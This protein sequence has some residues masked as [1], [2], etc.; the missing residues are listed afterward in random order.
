MIPTLIPHKILFIAMAAV[1]AM[2][3]LLGIL[4]LAMRGGTAK[5][6]E[7]ITLTVWGFEDEGVYKRTFDTFKQAHPKTEV[8]YRKQNPKQYLDR[9]KTRRNNTRPGERPDIFLMHN[10]WSLQVRDLVNPAPA[11]VITEKTFQQLFYPVA[12][13]DFVIDGQI[14]GLPTSSDNLALFYNPSLLAE[15][16]LSA[17]QD[18]EAFSQAAVRLTTR[19]DTGT[20]QT[21]GAAIGAAKN[22]TYF[23]D[24]LGAMFLQQGVNPTLLG[25]EETDSIIEYYAGDITK[26]AKGVGRVWDPNAERDIDAFAKGKVAMIF[27]PGI[28]AREIMSKNPTLIFTTAPVPQLRPEEPRTFATYWAWGVSRYAPNSHLAWQL[29]WKLTERAALI[30]VNNALVAQ[31]R[32][33]VPYPRRDMATRQ[34]N[35]PVLGAFIRQAGDAESLVMASQTQDGGMNDKINQLLADAITKKVSGQ[36]VDLKQLASQIKAILEGG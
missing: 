18:W 24:I 10:T 27:A 11:D 8:I 31:Y 28:A 14:I 23:S 29:A 4:A 17:P 25:E 7:N 34:I 36:G 26:F 15:K 12:A 3:G 33:G 22:I 21:A 35:D 13:D 9:I 2:L 6:P 32:I 16:G 30:R 5:A 1:L 19:D 20:P